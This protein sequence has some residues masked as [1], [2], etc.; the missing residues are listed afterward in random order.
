VKRLAGLVLISALVG[1]AVAGCASERTSHE[2]MDGRIQLSRRE[3]EGERAFMRHCHECHPG[4]E[5]GV[6]PSVVG[7]PEA[8]V[9]AQI[10]L[11]AGA[12]PSF[13]ARRIPDDE[14]AAIAAYVSALGRVQDAP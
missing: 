10:R 6:G 7:R 8:L 13:D 3:A 1:S 5:A 4:G 9:K 2:L 12:M 11:G 14:V